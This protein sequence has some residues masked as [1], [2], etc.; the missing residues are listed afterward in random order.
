MQRAEWEFQEAV[1]VLAAA[2]AAAAHGSSKAGQE[3]E[4]SYSQP[5]ESRNCSGDGVASAPVDKQ[6]LVRAVESLV[7]ARDARED[8]QQLVASCARL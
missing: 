3:G 4:N 7:Q 8:L 1:V 2:A 5:K 6:Q